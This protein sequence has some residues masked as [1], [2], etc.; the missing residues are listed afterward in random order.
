MN[1]LLQIT[2]DDDGRAHFFSDYVCV[3]DQISLQISLRRHTE[4]YA[5]PNP[6]VAEDLILWRRAKAR[7]QGVP[8]YF[9]LHQRVLYD[10]ADRLPVTEEELMEI[11]GIGPKMCD[12][13]G[14]EIL[15]ITS[16]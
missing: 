4:P 12:K 14:R 10:I 8:P 16:L 11:P 13:Y 6:D 7:E 5:G 3:E 2:V 1:T 9:I 15:E